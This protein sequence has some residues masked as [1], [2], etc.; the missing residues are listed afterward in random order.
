MMNA[1]VKYGGAAK[2]LK[3]VAENP[4]LFVKAAEIAVEGG[5]M[6]FD[7]ISESKKYRH[8]VDMKDMDIYNELLKD[9]N[10]SFNEKMEILEKKER[11]IDKIYEKDSEDKEREFHALEFVAGTFFGGPIFIAAYFGVK[12]YQKQ[13]QQ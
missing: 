6:A 12:Q 11:R 5:K 9:P 7:A 13:N 2:I 4:E 10:L 1:M 3:T 8:E